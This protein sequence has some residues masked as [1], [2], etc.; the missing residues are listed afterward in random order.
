MRFARFLTN[1]LSS[2]LLIFILVWQ[3]SVKNQQIHEFQITDFDSVDSIVGR[4]RVWL[5]FS[6]LTSS[7]TKSAYLLPFLRVKSYDDN[8]DDSFGRIQ[9]AACWC[10]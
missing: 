7:G 10:V 5:G 2:N 1:L 8:D 9:P 6:L 3:A 4:E